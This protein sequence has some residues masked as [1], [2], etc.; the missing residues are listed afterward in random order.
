MTFLEK[1]RKRFLLD[2]IIR[3]FIRLNRVRLSK[4]ISSP[5]PNS[6]LLFNFFDAIT[7]RLIVTPI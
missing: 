1:I 3:E 5:D 6:I 7:K 4:I 2:G